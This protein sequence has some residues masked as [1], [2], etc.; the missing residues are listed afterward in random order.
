MSMF[1]SKKLDIGSFVNTHVLRD[2]TKR[3]TYAQFEPERQALRHIIRNTTLPG[4]RGQ[5]PS[6]SSPRCTAIPDLHRSAADVCWAERGVVYSEILRCH[7]Y[8]S[9]TSKSAIQK[10]LTMNPQYN[11]RMQAL[12]GNIPGVRKASW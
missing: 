7:E 8:V 4:E 12:V 3:K 5:R 1:R 9:K 6:F 2:H 10:L 11:F